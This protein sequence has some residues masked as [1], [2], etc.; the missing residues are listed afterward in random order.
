MRSLHAAAGATARHVTSTRTLMGMLGVL[1][2]LGLLALA[3]G[4]AGLGDAPMP[5][6]VA[7]SPACRAAPL[8]TTTLYLRGSMNQWQPDDAG[9]VVAR[10]LRAVGPSQ[11]RLGHERLDQPGEAAGEHG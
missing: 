8:G 9:E 6:G 1:G 11:E 2:V 5:P 7:S 3:A 10:G 4:C